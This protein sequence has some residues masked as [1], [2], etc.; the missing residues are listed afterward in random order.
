MRGLWL[1]R[2]RGKTTFPMALPSAR[3]RA[4]L[5]RIPY[6]QPGIVEASLRSSALILS[7]KH[8]PGLG[9][10]FA[11]TSWPVCIAVLG[12]LLTQKPG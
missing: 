6:L 4:S 2:G 10:I 9:S 11:E 7:L 5:G 12:L 8:M 3:L 1:Q